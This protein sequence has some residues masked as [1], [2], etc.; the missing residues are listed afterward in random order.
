MHFCPAFSLESDRLPTPNL[1]WRLFVIGCWYLKLLALLI[2]TIDI[3]FIHVE[4]LD[5]R[6]Y[7][8]LYDVAAA[9]EINIFFLQGHPTVCPVCGQHLLEGWSKRSMNAERFLRSDWKDLLY[10]LV[11][12]WKTWQ[13]ANHITYIYIYKMQMLK[14]WDQYTHTCDCI[15]IRHKPQN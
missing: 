4:I 2:L 12:H 1:I 9:H 15:C 11:Y 14:K 8:C 7:V 3:C 5:S 6:W 13:Y 10:S